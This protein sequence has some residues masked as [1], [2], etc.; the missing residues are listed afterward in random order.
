MLSQYE[1]MLPVRLTAD[2]VAVR[3]L[4]Q[5]KARGELEALTARMKK[6]LA[7]AREVRRQLEEEVTETARA[8][9]EGMEPRTVRIFVVADYQRGVAE[10]VRSDTHEVLDGRSRPLEPREKQVRLFDDHSPVP[11]L[12]LPIEEQTNPGMVRPV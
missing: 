11:G 1:E 8:V 9:R 4:R 12:H 2:E 7:N 6:L 5:A 3:A 10:H